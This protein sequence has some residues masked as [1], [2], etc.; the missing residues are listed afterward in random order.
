MSMVCCVSSNFLW[1]PTVGFQN[2]LAADLSM[3]KKT[4]NIE[5]DIPDTN[6]SLVGDPVKVGEN[7]G[8]L[9]CI[10]WGW[11]VKLSF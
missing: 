11:A 4:T 5:I 6:L 7:I 3:R 9:W 10:G 8:C 1:T 2:G